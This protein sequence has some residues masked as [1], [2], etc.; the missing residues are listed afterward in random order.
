MKLIGY[1][2]CDPMEGEKAIKEVT[3]ARQVLG[4]WGLK[5]NPR[6]ERWIDDI[7]GTTF[8]FSLPIVTN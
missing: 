4:I 7:K 6:L 8:Y 3:Y 1:A 2:C 5:L